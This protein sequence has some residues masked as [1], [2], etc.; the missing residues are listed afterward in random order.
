MR[1][2]QSSMNGDGKIGQLNAKVGNQTTFLHHIQN[3]FKGD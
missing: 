1:K 2:R 3:K